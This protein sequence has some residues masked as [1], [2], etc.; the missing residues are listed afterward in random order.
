MTLI[1]RLVRGLRRPRIRLSRE[2]IGD[3]QLAYMLKVGMAHPVIRGVMYLIECRIQGKMERLNL[4]M[5]KAELTYYLGAQDELLELLA[6]IEGLARVEE[7][8]GAE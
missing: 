2:V 6:E 1:Q 3:K 4:K 8:G 7:K 5:S